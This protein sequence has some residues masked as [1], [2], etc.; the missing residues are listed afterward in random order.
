[1]RQILTSVLTLTAVLSGAPGFGQRLVPQKDIS[2]AQ[3]AV[4]PTI[5]TILTLTNRGLYENGYAGVLFFRQGINGAVWNPIVN[6]TPAVD[7]EYAVTILPDETV[8]LKITGAE[9]LENGFVIL[10]ANDLILDN[11]VEANLTYFLRDGGAVVDSIG[12]PPSG[13]FYLTSIPFEQF[14][15]IALALA[16]PS[17]EPE[18]VQVLLTPIDGT[19]GKPLPG[20][21]IDLGSSSHTAQFL[22]E[23]FPGIEMGSG[24]VEISSSRPI[25]GTALTLVNGQLSSLPLLPSPIAYNLSFVGNAGSGIP[26]YDGALAL[27]AEGYFV[28]GYLVISR[29][30]DQEIESGFVTLVSGQ[31]IDRFLD[32]SF[33]AES[34]YLD[35]DASNN[36]L[37]TIYIGDNDFLFTDVQATGDWLFTYLSD[38]TTEGGT[39]TLNRTTP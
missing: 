36:R 20:K 7:G 12:V 23:L 18:P 24:K 15:S 21:S 31:L 11:F 1:M 13:E 25:V 34:R 2:F 5:E 4:G 27:W 33:F 17:T 39:F 9:S 19:D 10:Q 14:S 8:V 37:L 38:G 22:T 29:V 26:N 30:G 3:V 16:N 28:K 6:G 35:G 32:L